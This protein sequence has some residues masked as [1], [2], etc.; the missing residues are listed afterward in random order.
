[1]KSHNLCTKLTP[2]QGYDKLL[3]LG[4]TFCLQSRHP[5]QNFESSFI[6]FR[7]DIRTKYL[8]A[9]DKVNVDI[10]N[11]I[12]IKNPDWTP[13]IA[14]QELEK[15]I[16]KMEKTLNHAA[17]LNQHRFTTNL[18]KRQQELL[19]LLQNHNDFII[20]PSD[21]N[22]G[23]CILERDVYIK[24][25]LQ[26]HLSN[27][28]VYR[29]LHKEEAEY[30]FRSTQNKM[31]RIVAKAYQLEQ[32]NPQELLYFNRGIKINDKMFKF[33]ITLK[34]HKITLGNPEWKTRSVT[35]T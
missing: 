24:R 15:A 6:R 17:E 25:A 14:S 20:A 5:T 31:W 3:G 19:Q 28:K 29:K 13:E 34:I 18:T 26:D 23:P 33:Y 7:K 32:I 27:E 10:N 16:T 8:F 2:P 22:L 35:S 21:K 9:N 12:Y 4:L 1:M 11:K 30:I